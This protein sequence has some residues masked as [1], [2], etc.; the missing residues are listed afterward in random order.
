MIAASMHP[1]DPD[2]SLIRR[3]EEIAKYVTGILTPVGI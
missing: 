1:Y 2:S 3:I